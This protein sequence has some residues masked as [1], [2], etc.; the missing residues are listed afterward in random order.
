MRNVKIMVQADTTQAVGKVRELTGALAQLDEAAK[1]SAQYFLQT[2]GGVGLTPQ[3][4]GAVPGQQAAVAQ[5]QPQV[6]ASPVTQPAGTQ[7]GTPVSKSKNKGDDDTMKKLNDYTLKMAEKQFNLFSDELA[8][9]FSDAFSALFEGGFKG[10]LKSLTA[11]LKGLFKGLLKQLVGDIADRIKKAISKNLKSI[12]DKGTG[13]INIGS[14]GGGGG[15]SEDKDGGGTNVATPTVTPPGNSPVWNGGGGGSNPTPFDEM[16]M[17]SGG[18]MNQP[19]PIAQAN[20]PALSVPVPAG[21]TAPKGGVPGIPTKFSWGSFGKMIGSMAP[22]LGSSLGGMLGGTSLV[23][24]LMGSVGGLLGGTALGLATGA[25]SSTSG[26]MGGIV[27]ALGGATMATGILAGIGVALM[28]GAYFFGKN[29]QRKAD[30]KTRNQTMMDALNQLDE[31]LKQVNSDEIAGSAGVSQANSLRKQY[32]DQ[33][34]QL[35]DSKTRRIAL[36]DVSRLDSKISLIK[37]A[38]EQQT[39]RKAMDAKLVPTF[40]DGGLTGASAY[41]GYKVLGGDGAFMRPFRGRVPGIYD[42]KDDF[43]ARLS[44]NEVVLT[45]DVWK[46]IAPYLKHKRV[47]GFAGGGKVDSSLSS[48]FTGGGQASSNQEIIIEELTIH[49]SNQFGSETAARIVDIGLKTPG[50]QQAVVKS[51]R[52]HIGESGLSDGLVRD[53]NNVNDRGF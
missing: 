6:Q 2:L 35:K 3:Q 33:M 22:A 26:M 4:V 8:K 53:I 41:G 52:T 21:T 24:S 32:M 44:G 49:L 30:E 46:P 28:I 51:V 20:K 27:G 13:G 1:R 50:G 15:G 48:G 19:T 34:S 11:S 42:R 16:I 10:A 29:K 18:G 38:A 17:K 25:I 12:F 9:T 7:T 14:G 47:P 31:I 39:A 36:A 43:L 37:Q 23:G 40:A 45:P 5:A